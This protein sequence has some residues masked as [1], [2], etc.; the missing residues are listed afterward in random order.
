MHIHVPGPIDELN[1]ASYLVDVRDTTARGVVHN[2]FV[3]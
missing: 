1:D 2:T 3:G